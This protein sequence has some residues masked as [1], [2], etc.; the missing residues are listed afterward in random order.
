LPFLF[1]PTPELAARQ[2]ERWAIWFARELQKNANSLLEAETENAR[3]GKIGRS[4][5]SNG[6]KTVIRVT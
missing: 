6:T 3:S 2:I 5:Q 4:N 1:F